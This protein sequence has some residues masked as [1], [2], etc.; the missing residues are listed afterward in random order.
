MKALVSK[1]LGELEGDCL[2]IFAFEDEERGHIEELDNI[3]GGAIL[4]YLKGGDF[5]GK[6][7][8]IL[9][10]RRKG[11]FPERIALVGLGKRGNLK[12][13]T[14]LN[15]GGN[16]LKFA[17]E[18]NYRSLIFTSL[19]DGI[20]PLFSAKNLA[21]G[22]YLADY[23]FNRFK[24]VDDERKPL[25][26][27]FL[28]RRYEKVIEE[29]VRR[30]EIISNWIKFARDLGNT[31]GNYL[32]PLKMAEIAKEEAS[33]RGIKCQIL[34]KEQLESLGMGGLLA[35]SK[36]SSEKPC[37]IILEY[38]SDEKSGKTVLVGKGITFDSGGI[39]LKSREGMG[40]M[41]YDMS[42]GAAVI[43]TIFAASELEIPHNVIGLVPA[44]EN[45]PGGSALKPGDVVRHYNG[46]T[47]EIVS[48]DAEGRLILA[49]VLS[50]AEEKF[51]PERIVDIAT[52]TGACVIALGHEVAGIMGNDDELVETLIEIGKETG[53]LLWRLPLYEGYSRQ[54]RSEVADI[55]NS[56]GRP[57]GAITAAIFL[58]NFIKKSPWAH[59]DIAGK[60]WAEAELVR[61]WKPKGCTGFGV[62][63]LVEF[64]RE[65]TKVTD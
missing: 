55:K 19:Y 15:G 57:A 25:K 53:E 49:D 10:V 8:E 58:K 44:T 24:G 7:G 3:L 6:E 9:L 34:E 52:L 63:L 2:F 64:L 46:L 26:I 37:L 43:S 14:L 21:Y 56:G 32:T 42:G 54:I 13:E 12:I 23:S 18:K 65:L 22:A 16:A 28:V 41:K 45:L 11:K 40:R 51:C 35:V 39:S 38:N 31:P 30:A 33:K 48:T 50:Y 36:G 29:E 60:A 20:D 61:P 17:R 47:S 1:N 27:S 62:R 59:I 5:R 4:D